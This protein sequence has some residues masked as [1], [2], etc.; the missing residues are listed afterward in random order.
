MY[1][2]YGQQMPPQPLRLNHS[3]PSSHRPRSITVPMSIPLASP[4]SAHAYPTAPSSAGSVYL[5][6]HQQQQQHHHL[7]MSSNIALGSTPIV[8]QGSN[9]SMNSASGALRPSSSS[10]R[11]D[12]YATST[13]SPRM[14]QPN[15]S[16]SLHNRRQSQP[17]TQAPPATHDYYAS[18]SAHASA[19]DVSKLPPMSPVTGTS[20]MNGHGDHNAHS[21]PYHYQP[22]A[23]APGAFASFH[24]TYSPSSPSSQQQHHT[25]Q[26][27]HAQ[28][29]SQQNHQA[30]MSSP[31][32][33]QQHQQHLSYGAPQYTQWQP[34]PVAPTSAGRYMPQTQAPRDYAFGHPPPLQLAANNS[35]PPGPGTGSST[36]SSAHHH[37]AH[38]H[39]SDYGS[40]SPDHHGNGT[41]LH[42]PPIQPIH[43]G[44]GQGHWDHHAPHQQ[45]HPSQHG[46]PHPEHHV[47]LAPIA[48]GWEGPAYASIPDGN[49]WRNQGTSV[50]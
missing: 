46:H 14:S 4:S 47:P 22:P 1:D 44:A 50:G 41:S 20:G 33:Q 39:Q 38:G 6:S 31:E 15:G 32:Q 25:P 16:S 28:P 9:S 34:S 5:G 2:Q 37:M 26:H 10:R 48:A 40:S 12:P 18:S 21:S 7:A 36:S 11:Y 23:T 8:R 43:D 19:Y 30:H 13:S 24:S 29:P 42:A 27:H 35:V 49:E 17:V 45:I 3:S